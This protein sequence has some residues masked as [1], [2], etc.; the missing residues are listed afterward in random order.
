M[1]T[2]GIIT[3][4]VSILVVL[5]G[6][7]PTV[8]VLPFNLEGV[9]SQAIYGIHKLVIYFPP[10]GTVITAFIIYVLFRLTLVIMKMILGSR[11]PAI[12]NL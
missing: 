11:L 10:L 5:F 8:T 12:N 2:A 4:F 9:V 3:V 6:W 7:L 1:I